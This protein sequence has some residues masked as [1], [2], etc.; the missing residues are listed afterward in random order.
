MA[1]GAGRGVWVKGWVADGSFK[2]EDVEVGM[3][4]G[5][6]TG[7]AQAVRIIPIIRNM[8]VSRCMAHALYFRGLLSGA[9]Y[10]ILD[11]PLRI[12]IYD[13]FACS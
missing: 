11:L 7:E 5:V 9:A 13:L 3:T 10:T 6:E 2:T 1:V 12:P 8:Y 4:V